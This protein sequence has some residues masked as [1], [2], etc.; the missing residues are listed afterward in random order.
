MPDIVN[1]EVE[2]YAEAHTT[3]P[4]PHLV[5]LA[6][7]TRAELAAPGMMVGAV[8]GRFLELLVFALGARRVLE[9]GTFSGYSAI[10]MAAGLAPGG[11][12]TTCEL[13]PV[14]AAVARE[15]IAASGYADRVEV[16]EGP[17]LQTVSGLDGPFD[18]VFIDADKGNYLAYYEAVLPKL[19]PHGLIAADNTLWSGNVLDPRDLSE[20]T[21]ALRAFNDVLAADERVV[22]VQLTVRDGVTLVRRAPGH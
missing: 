10:A 16:V 7:R 18:F 15:A 19:A 11:T 4:P 20:D 21:Q 22:C 2:S 6:E 12:L 17:A 9:I 5:A 14:H 13:S 1:A 8:E 3:A